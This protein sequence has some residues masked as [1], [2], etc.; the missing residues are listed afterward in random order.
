MSKQFKA[1]ISLLLITL[2]WGTSFA[3]MKN[4]LEYL[5]SFA[6][7]AMR[8]IIAAL[9]L[10]IVF[11]KSM[12]KT[13][14][15]TLLLGSVLGILLFSIMAFQVVGLNY[16]T[17]SN[18]AFITGLN[19]VMVPIVSAYFLKKKPDSS[20]VIGVILAFVGIF[21]LTGMMDFSA[22]TG[23]HF[24]LT[25]NLGDLLTFICAACV[26]L[27]IIFIDKFTEKHDPKVLSVV[28]VY[29]AA[30]LYCILWL[31]VD[32]RPFE[33]NGAVIFTLLLTGVLGT[34]A[35]FAGQTILQKDTTPTHTALIFTA[36][37]V[38]GAVFALIIPNT[39]GV[40]EALK[41]NT[42]LGAVL[43]ISGMLI[44][45]LMPSKNRL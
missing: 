37:P 14:K 45:E 35:A 39:A 9:V 16:T 17:A 40:V 4:V 13:N 43:I 24:K 31:F 6:Y 38:F 3:L 8:F 41:L 7:L 42:V 21:L 33:F 34:A 12:L 29:V 30:A 44:S 27:Q 36:E 11:H 23:L 18:S 22:T 1:D 2:V 28:Q 15:K 19:V 20:S 5:P 32:N 25:F 10:V 26:T